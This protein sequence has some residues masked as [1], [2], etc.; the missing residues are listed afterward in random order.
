[1]SIYF[2]SEGDKMNIYRGKVEDARGKVAI[3]VSQYNDY[4]TNRLLSGALEALK[5]Q[6]VSPEDTDLVYVPGVLE[7]PLLVK[8]LLDQESYVA[9]ICLG[10]VI[11]HEKFSTHFVTDEAT[12]QL[13][14]L[15]LDYKCPVINGILVTNTTSDAFDQSGVDHGNS[16]YQFAVTA[17]EMASLMSKVRA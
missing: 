11:R 17:L 12:G 4:V 8:T 5:D 13:T 3:V 14:Q 10:A 15:S 16:G 2:T 6:G 7:M 9:V 1:M